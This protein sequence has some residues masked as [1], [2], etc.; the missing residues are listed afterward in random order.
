MV[1]LVTTTTQHETTVILGGKG[2][3]GRRV[4]QRLAAKGLPSRI[5]SRSTP[6]PFDWND[7]ATWEPALAGA[8]ALYITY[9]PDLSIPG[10]AQQVG[11]VSRLAADR[12]VRRIVLLA[13]RGEPEVEPAEQAVRESGADTTILECAFFSQNFD[14][15]LLVPVDDQIVFVAG[16]VPEPFIDCDDIADVAV[17]ALT[18]DGH[19]GKT[20]DLT[21][22]RA[23]TFAEATASLAAATGRPLRYVPVSF[24]EY[25]QLLAP[26]M[27][28]EL[29]GFFVELFRRL[30]DGHNA[31]PTDG[32]ER[33]LGRKPRDFHAYAQGVAGAWAEAGQ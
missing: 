6:V 22:P 18:E 4:A 10:A 11:R 24:E 30:L 7:E 15:G 33:A 16:D 32:V 19:A 29:A 31:Q 27:P 28:G 13:G 12:G 25:G 9:F 3:T 1:S 20:Y 26:H 21:G 5:A 23:L 2:K 17:A 14:E 8:G